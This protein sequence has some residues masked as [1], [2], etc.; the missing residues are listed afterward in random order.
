[1]YAVQWNSGAY[2]VY[3]VSVG[4][5]RIRKH[6]QD[7]TWGA[8][9]YVDYLL[10]P[11]QKYTIDLHVIGHRT[12][13]C[14]GIVYNSATTVVGSTGSADSLNQ[15]IA[16]KNYGFSANYGVVTDDEYVTLTFDG[17]AN[18]LC[19]YVN[20]GPLNT[21]EGKTGTEDCKGVTLSDPGKSVA[22]NFWRFSFQAYHTNSGISGKHDIVNRYGLNGYKNGDASA[23]EAIDASFIAGFTKLVPSS[24]LG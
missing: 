6:T 18:Q 14:Y 11:T 7:S 9:A 3:E 19:L 12:H 13:D 16:L 17:P 4:G 21:I 2:G 24:D 8:Y 23:G 5:S 10:L 20:G 15:D 22:D 1:M